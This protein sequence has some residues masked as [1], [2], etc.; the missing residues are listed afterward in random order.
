MFMLNRLDA[1]TRASFHQHGEPDELP[2]S[3]VLVFPNGQRSYDQ[4]LGDYAVDEL[5]QA[6]EPTQVIEE[7]FSIVLRLERMLG[8]AYAMV[9]ASTLSFVVLVLTL[10]L[11]LRREEIS[12]L[13][14]MGCSKG[15]VTSLIVAELILIGIAAVVVASIGTVAANEAATV[16]GFEDEMRDTGGRNG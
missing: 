14:R 2:I 1:K 10:S 16:S 5:L 13:R 8:A 11:R 15:T 3:A 9:A 6:V 4:I 12:L 7:V